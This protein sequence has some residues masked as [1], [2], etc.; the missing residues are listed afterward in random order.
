VADKNGL[1]LYE[2]L[3]QQI[4]SLLKIKNLK[5][6][7]FLEIDPSQTEEISRIIKQY[8]PQ[9]NIEVKKDFGGLDRLIK[10]KI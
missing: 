2:E 1:A 7:I 10:I 6:K 9:S 3:L 5:L 8:F 4:Q